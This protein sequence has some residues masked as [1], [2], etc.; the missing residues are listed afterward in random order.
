M[1]DVK[2]RIMVKESELVT[3]REVADMLRVHINTV[4]HWSDK[5]ILKSVRIGPRGD[6]RFRRDAILKMSEELR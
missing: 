5:G 4:R 3:T 6:R 1:A 2:E